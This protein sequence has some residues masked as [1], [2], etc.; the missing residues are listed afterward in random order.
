MVEVEVEIILSIHLFGFTFHNPDIVFGEFFW[1]NRHS[2]STKTHQR[3]FWGVKRVPMEA[4]ARAERSFSSALSEFP[5]SGGRFSFDTGLTAFSSL[6]CESLTSFSSTSF[7]RSGMGNFK[8]IPTSTKIVNGRKISTKRLS[9]WS[10]K[11]RS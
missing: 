5:S 11:C 6:G 8:S 10:R 4:G 1:Q 9:R 7:S 3:I 2:T